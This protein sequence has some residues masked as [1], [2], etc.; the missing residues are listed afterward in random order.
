M[1]KYMVVFELDGKVRWEV[2]AGLSEKDA[3]QWLACNRATA[4]LV[5]VVP[6]VEIVGRM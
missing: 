5:L 3:R 2:V 4:D 6:V 1:T